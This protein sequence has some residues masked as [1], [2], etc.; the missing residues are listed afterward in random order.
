MIR[1][2]FPFLKTKK[3]VALVVVMLLL[4]IGGGLAG[5]AALH[6]GGGAAAAQNIITSDAEFYGQSPP[7]YPSRTYSSLSYLTLPDPALHPVLSRSS[8]DL[9]PATS[10]GTER[11]L[12]ITTRAC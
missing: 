12:I 6:H 9:M 2:R 10:W 11:K 8:T 4:I 1:E 7:V 5:L 3:G